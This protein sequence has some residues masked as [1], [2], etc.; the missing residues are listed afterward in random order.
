MRARRP[1]LFISF[2]G[3]DGAGKSSQIGRLADH[4][5][6][7]GMTVRVTREPGGTDNAE[8]VRKLLVT[9]KAESWGPL[10]ESLLVNAA[11]ADHLDRVIRPA[12]DRGD[13]VI[14]DRFADSTTAYQ[15]IAGGLGEATVEAL[16]AIVVGDDEPDLTIILDLPVEVGLSRARGR[17]DADSRFESKG[18]AYQ[19]RVRQAFLAIA[20]KNPDRCVVVDATPDEASV[21]DAIEDAVGKML[22]ARQ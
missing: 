14:T 19:E 10:A 11:R 15:G 22:G 2:E 3:G 6:R 12:L 18:V 7:L 20:R 17:G 4:L 5:R 16:R 1:G 8:A 9:G 21:F 13:V